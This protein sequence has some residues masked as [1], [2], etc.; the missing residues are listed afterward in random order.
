MLTRPGASSDLM[1][2]GRL[3]EAVAAEQKQAWYQ[4]APQETAQQLD[5]D[6]A[7]GL[8]AAEAQRRLQQ[9]EY[10]PNRLAGKQKESGLHALTGMDTEIGHIAKLLDQ[11]TAQKTPLQKQL[12][13][14][15]I[16]LAGIAGLTFILMLIL[17]LARGQEVQEPLIAGIALAIAAITTGL[18]ATLATPA[19]SQARIQ[20]PAARLWPGSWRAR[21]AA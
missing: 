10:G 20:S 15:T 12:D 13:R 5:V 21:Y 3:I 8:S 17:G 6:V 2:G 9:Y 18:P 14:L 7:K 16:V 19:T 4:L 11:A 1:K